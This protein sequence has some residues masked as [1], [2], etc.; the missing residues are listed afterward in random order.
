MKKAAFYTL[1]CKLNLTETALIS[2][3]FENRGYEPVDFIENPD[4]FVI[5]TCSVTE[6]ADRKCKKVVR[7]AKKISPYSQVFVVG[8]YAQLKP[9][10]IMRIPGVTAVFGANEKFRI[11]YLLENKYRNSG[12][13][14]EGLKFVPAY[15]GEERTRLF[16]KVQDGCDYTCSFCT[17]PLA[18]GKSRSSN[19]LELV[20]LARKAVLENQSK[21]L[22]LTGINLGDFGIID[23]KRE[24]KFIDLLQAFEDAEGIPRIRISSIEPNLLSEDIIRKVAS[25]K[26]ITPHFHIPLQSGNNTILGKMKRRYKRE[27]FQEKMHLIKSYMPDACIGVDVIVGFPG[28]GVSEFLDTYKFLDSLA[29]S[30]LHVFPYSERDN[31][32]A[33]HLPDLVPQKERA[34]R[35]NDLRQLSDRKKEEFYN[36]QIDTI[37][38]V[39]FESKVS[40]GQM[41]GFT[42]NYV[43]VSAPYNPEDVNEIKKIKIQ[44]LGKNLVCKGVDLPAASFVI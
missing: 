32:L 43:R 6:N 38:E 37:R 39:L 42:E 24:E 30:Y 9:L 23:G 29:V 44:E 35:A 8:C 14:L 31:T 34:Q 40:E 36:S 15:S 33:T 16:F 26:K 2:K 7:E 10:E 17:I 5:N 22:I 11:P 1:G 25:S 18:R 3:E 12:N 28:E 13:S 4:V 21:E 27:L 19:S 41:F 20:E